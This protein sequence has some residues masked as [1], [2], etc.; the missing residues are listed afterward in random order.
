MDA[1]KRIERSVDSLQKIYAVIV[2]L[3]IVQAVQVLLFV[4]RGKSAIATWPEIQGRLPAFLGFVAVLVPFF[5]GLNRHLDRCYLDRTQGKR[6]SSSL[7]FDF[8]IFFGESCV[9]FMIAATI[10]DGLRAFLFIGI[11]LVVDAIWAAICYPIHYRGVKPSVL[12][13]T[14]INL[15]T[16]MLGVL[17]ALVRFMDSQAKVWS[18]FG[19]AAARTAADY[20]LC[21]GL[22][23][24]PQEE[25]AGS[26]ERGGAAG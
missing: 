12:H 16:I 15:V 26:T 6:A 13:W 20:R 21:W 23:F 3:A 8:F 2:G 5:H 22:Y 14:V 24:P 19:L 9:L 4:E 11:L 18:L 1:A 7:L 10:A 17:V 25:N